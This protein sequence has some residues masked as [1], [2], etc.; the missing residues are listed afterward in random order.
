MP[1]STY[2]GGIVFHIVNKY[3]HIVLC[4]LVLK[5]KC[6]NKF[7]CCSLSDSDS[8]SSSELE[9]SDSEILGFFVAMM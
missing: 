5:T 8:V 9:L 3:I 6:Y 1:L 2:K 4:L 7:T